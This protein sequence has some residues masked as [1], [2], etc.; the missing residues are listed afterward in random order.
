MPLLHSERSSKAGLL[1]GILLGIP[2]GLG[3]FTFGY[4]RGASYLTDNADACANCHVMRE[5]RAGWMKAS[6]RT[7][8]VCN[9]CHTPD[10][11]VPKYITKMRNG[12]LHSLAFTTGY[13]PDEIQ[14]TQHSSNVAENAC[15]KCHAEVVS[16]IESVRK[17]N[18]NISCIQCHSRVGHL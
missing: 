7:A 18:E 8:A 3:F 12:F 6:H 2:I 1:V 13:F 14:A 10:G 17:H 15:A 5:H 9:D 11:L 16:S 4:A